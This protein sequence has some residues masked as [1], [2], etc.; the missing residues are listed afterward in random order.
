[1]NEKK[2]YKSETGRV[3][4]AYACGHTLPVAYRV[5]RHRK[6]GTKELTLKFDI[7]DRLDACSSCKLSTLEKAAL[8]AEDQMPEEA[9]VLAPGEDPGPMEASAEACAGCPGEEDCTSTDGCIEEATAADNHPASASCAGCALE[10]ED[11]QIII[12][13]GTP[14]PE[15]Q[16]AKPR[17]EII[18]HDGNAFAI[19]GAAS[20]AA[21]KAGWP[22]A[23]VQQMISRATAGNYDHLL[24]TISE[25]FD[26][27]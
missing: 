16:A 18:G 27:C 13:E 22:S 3:E 25:Y 6:A 2:T 9:G 19:L 14:C 7:D 26:V 5:T 21:R 12:A 15:Y 23:K 20:K 24:A 1:M 11:C 10:H 8:K 17:L 4:I